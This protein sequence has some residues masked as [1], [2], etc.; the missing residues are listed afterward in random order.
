MCW[1]R[2]GSDDLDRRVEYDEREF[3][4]IVSAVSILCEDGGTERTLRAGDC[5][6]LRTG[7]RGSW[8]VIET[9]R[10]AYVIR[11]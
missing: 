11:L 9:T 8:E 5:F 3:C 2:C 4:H 1:N 10:K 7:F 6:V